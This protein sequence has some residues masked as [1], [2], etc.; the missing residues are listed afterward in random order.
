MTFILAIAFTPWILYV[1]SIDTISNA[2][3]LLIP[4]TSVNVF[5]TF[6]QFIF[7][8]QNDHLNTLL[9]SLWPLSVLLGFLALRENKRVPPEVIYLLLSVLIPIIAAFI[10]SITIRPLF[11]SRYLILTIPTLYLFIGWIFSTYPHK[12]RRIFATILIFG[13]LASLTVEAISPSAPV[14]EDY[15]SAVAY[16]GANATAQDVIIL[17]AP[18]TVYPVEYYY[19]GPTEIETLPIWNRFVSGPIPPFNEQT[20]PQQ[21][22]ILKGSHEKAWLLLSYDQG[23]EQTIQV[24]MDTHFERIDKETF[25]PGLTLYVYRLRYD[26]QVLTTN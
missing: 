5:N 22:A 21:V 12:L 16:L 25:S 4:P 17:S 15:E 9:V 14:K 19:K 10:V 13:M 6:S 11:V 26:P 2:V 3:P 8:F 23:Y 18:F 20:L 24:Y 1:R 7:G